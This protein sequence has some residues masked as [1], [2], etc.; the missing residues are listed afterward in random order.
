MDRGFKEEQVGVQAKPFLSGQGHRKGIGGGSNWL[1]T[2]HVLHMPCTGHT[3]AWVG[4]SAR[5]AVIFGHKD[6]S[7]ISSTFYHSSPYSGKAKFCPPARSSR[8][9]KSPSSSSA[10]SRPVS[11][12]KDH[13]PICPPS[14]AAFRIEVMPCARCKA[15]Q[16]LSWVQIMPKSNQLRPGTARDMC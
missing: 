13:F 9:S 4:P 7:T 1:C 16:L 14:K 5:N 8:P 10:S 2:G 3:S 11:N 6:L 15:R 12:A